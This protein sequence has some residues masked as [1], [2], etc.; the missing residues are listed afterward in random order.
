[1]GDG[2]QVQAADFAMCGKK[3]VDPKPWGL[4]RI[5]LDNV[6]SN[7]K[8]FAKGKQTLRRLA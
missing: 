4:M 8:I 2:Q 3:L 5:F 6:V 7:S 1:M